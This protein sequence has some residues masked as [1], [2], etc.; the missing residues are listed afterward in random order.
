[1]LFLSMPVTPATAVLFD[2]AYVQAQFPVIAAR[3]QRDAQQAAATSARSNSAAAQCEANSGAF[4]ML[5]YVLVG[6]CGCGYFLYY[7]AVSMVPILV[8]LSE[9]SLF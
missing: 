3:L 5:F 8:R 7:F 2:S 9:Q 4:F 6:G 1:M